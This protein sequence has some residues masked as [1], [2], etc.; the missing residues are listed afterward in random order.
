MFAI[1]FRADVGI[2]LDGDADR[3]VLV[4]QLGNTVDGDQIMAA[5]ATAWQSMG[6]LKSD[7]IV[8]TAMSNLGLE[9]YLKTRNLNL[10]RTEVGDR[11]VLEYMRASGCNLGGEQSGHIILSDYATTGDGIIAALQMLAIAVSA[12]KT[13]SEITRI[14]D[15]LPQQLLNLRIGNINPLDEEEVKKIIKWFN[16]KKSLDFEIDQDLAGGAS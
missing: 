2:A 7:N 3:L 4:D 9:K 6:R 14:F 10:F 11:Y 12:N 1:P 13:I 8:G 5:I 15:P 16:V